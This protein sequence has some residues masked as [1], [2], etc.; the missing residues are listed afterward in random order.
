MWGRFAG[1]I[2]A[3]FALLA[4]ASGTAAAQDRAGEFDHY[5]LALS[6]NAG[7]CAA[8][9]DARDADQCDPREEIGFLLHGLWPQYVDGWPEFCRSATRDASRRET[10]AMAD[11]M[12][13]GGLAWYQWRKHGRCSGLD[14]AAYFDLARRAFESIARPVELRRLRSAVEIDPEVIEAAFLEIN[15][16]LG[17]DMVSI[18][19]RDGRFREVRICL[20]R[21]LEPISCP[22]R[23]ARD[24][25][26]RLITLD[27]MR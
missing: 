13:S 7:W 16:G 23:G 9:G 4:Q 20:D 26:A 14:P 25:R 17:D 19:C 1:H 5:V 3:I 21:D 6:W 12:G 24:C 15:P 11:I 10:A 18:T 2:L 8:K 27:P 22:G